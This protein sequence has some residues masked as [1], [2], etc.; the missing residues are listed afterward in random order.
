MEAVKKLGENWKKRRIM[1]QQE[2]ETKF[3]VLQPQSN[4]Q[5]PVVALSD[6]MG[7][8]FPLFEFNVNSIDLWLD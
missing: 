2:Q 5:Q 6:V 4:L 8:M 1:L 7:L 3:K